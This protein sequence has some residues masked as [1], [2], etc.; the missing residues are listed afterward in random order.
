VALIQWRSKLSGTY[1]PQVRCKM[2]SSKFQQAWD[3]KR[4]NYLMAGVDKKSGLGIICGTKVR[5][6]VCDRSTMLFTL[7]NGADAN[8]TIDRINKIKSGTGSNP[9]A[10]SSEDGIV[11]FLSIIN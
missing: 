10:Q 1:T 2:V 4:L 5:A 9:L 6:A 8:E 7:A 3:T 11:D